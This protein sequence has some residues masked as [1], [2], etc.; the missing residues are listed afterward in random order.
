[1][2]W[3]Q[4]SRV[5]LKL[6]S[7]RKLQD[8]GVC[9][10][11]DPPERGADQSSDGLP[12]IGPVECVEEF[13]PELQPAEPFADPEALDYREIR[14]ESARAAEQVTSR[15]AVAAGLVRHECGRV[16]VLP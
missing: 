7:Q 5:S 1:M 13:G 6:I 3:N 2:S 11:L 8:A 15:A 9:R 12:E 14:V 10:R 4:I 16:E